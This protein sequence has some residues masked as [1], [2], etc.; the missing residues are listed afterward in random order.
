MTALGELL[1]ALHDA[2][3][4]QSFSGRAR[5]GHDPE[6]MREALERFNRSGGGHSRSVMPTATGPGFAPPSGMQESPIEFWYSVDQWRIDDGPARTIGT[7]SE[8]FR[9]HPGMGGV[10]TSV[11]DQ[12]SGLFDGFATYFAPAELL[13]SLHFQIMDEVVRHGRS[14]WHV[15]TEIVASPHPRFLPLLHGGED[16][17]LWVDRALG[18]VSRCEGRLDGELA[19]FFEIDELVVDEPIDP[20]VFAFVTPDGSPLR[21]QGEMQLEH[22]RAPGVD[23]SGID[24][25][26]PEQ[27]QQALHANM[28]AFARP[29]EIDQLASQH[30]PTGPP[31]D[32]EESARIDIG[33]VFQTMGKPSEDGTGLPSVER[34]ENLGP[35]A[36]EIRKRHP[37]YTEGVTQ[38]RI[39]RIKF[40]RPS[41]AVVWSS[42]PQL[43]MHEG[44]ALL[45]EGSW[46]VSR[47]TYCSL[48][49]MGGVICPP[50]VEPG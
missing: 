9:F 23:V 30:I 41:E 39:E 38:L 5:R 24:P 36:V 22:L 8:V 31:P 35:C 12:P 45:V 18:V 6:K 2:P 33:A 4:A 42:T 20:D 13:G 15:A 11:S 25:S 46:K 10:V 21:T 48:V 44:R 3:R 19:S 14:C 16:F 7:G 27:V 37:E 26:D 1:E 47:A 50:P 32:D 40:L 29:P 49:A 34:G 28:S 43:P 17:E